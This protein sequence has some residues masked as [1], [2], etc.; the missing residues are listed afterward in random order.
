MIRF[1]RNR[2]TRPSVGVH[3]TP[4]GY[5]AIAI[6]NGPRVKHVKEVL[7]ATYAKNDNAGNNVA[8]LATISVDRSQPPQA[9]VPS[10]DTSRKA[11][12]FD[13]SVVSRMTPTMKSFTLEGKVAIVTG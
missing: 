8:E 4:L 11:I 2:S 12:T 5:R 3:F 13:R 10:G 6:S 1:L 7:V 9:F